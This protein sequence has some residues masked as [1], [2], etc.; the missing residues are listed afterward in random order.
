MKDFKIG[1]KVVID[2]LI[3]QNLNV[4]KGTGTI[5][6]IKYEGDEILYGVEWEHEFHYCKAFE[7]DLAEE[8]SMKS[9]KKNKKVELLTHLCKVFGFNGLDDTQSRV[10]GDNRDAIFVALNIMKEDIINSFRK[11]FTAKL[12]E[13]NLTSKGC[14]TVLRQL[15]RSEGKYLISTKKHRYDKNAKRSK[16]YRVYFIR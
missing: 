9:N 14:F 15:L 8:E 13:K 7:I 1:T 16:S 5:S 11:P 6:S 3:A 4:P 12:R 2:H 10:N